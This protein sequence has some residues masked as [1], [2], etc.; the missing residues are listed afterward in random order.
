MNRNLGRNI[1]VGLVFGTAALTLLTV[2]AQV[3]R[4]AR[5]LAEVYPFTTGAVTFFPLGLLTYYAVQ[6]ARIRWANRA[7][8][9]VARARARKADLARASLLVH[10]EPRALTGVL[11]TTRPEPHPLTPDP[12]RVPPWAPTPFDPAALGLDK[13]YHGDL[14]DVLDEL[15]QR[16]TLPSGGRH[17]AKEVAA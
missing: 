3:V 11:V 6:T 8:V 1:G 12:F 7:E 2:S 10:P 4:I 14:G 9:R 15:R 13:Q 5:A 17:R 16:G